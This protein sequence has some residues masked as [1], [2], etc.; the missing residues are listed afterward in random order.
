MYHCAELGAIHVD[1]AMKQPFARRLPAPL[2]L[3]RQIY[4]HDVF[5]R[6][7]LGAETGR[8]D[9]KS[10]AATHAEIPGCAVTKPLRIEFFADKHQLGAKFRFV[11]FISLLT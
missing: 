9:Q 6:Q 2:R 11:H 4:E 10:F 7:P 1:I 5:I 8:R 3:T